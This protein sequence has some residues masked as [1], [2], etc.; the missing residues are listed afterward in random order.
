M[1]VALATS[2][3]K[4]ALIPGAVV[5]AIMAY[6]LYRPKANAYFCSAGRWAM[7][8]VLSVIF[9]SLSGLQFLS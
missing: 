5:L 6:F 4:V 3:L 9:L 7:R 8:K 2:P 1:I